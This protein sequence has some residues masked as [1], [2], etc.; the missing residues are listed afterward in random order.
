MGDCAIQI[1]SLGIHRFGEEKLQLGCL[2]GG[3]L[4][5]VR[6]DCVWCQH[7]GLGVKVSVFLDKPDRYII[8]QVLNSENWVGIIF[9]FY[10]YVSCPIYQLSLYPQY[11]SS[12]PIIEPRFVLFNSYRHDSLLVY[13]NWCT[14]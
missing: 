11:F 2:M 8:S 14:P 6:R 10:D 13:S 12:F 1:Q 9:F 5:G 3:V 4:V 7:T